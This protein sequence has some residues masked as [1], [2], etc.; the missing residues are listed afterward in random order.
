MTKL[1]QKL[2]APNVKRGDKSF[3]PVL[4]H[5]QRLGFKSRISTLPYE[6]D[7]L[8]PKLRDMSLNQSLASLAFGQ[9]I[10]VT[11]LQMAMAAAAVA[12]GGT[13]RPPRLVSAIEDDDGELA[14]VPAD[15]A[16]VHPVFTPATGA[17]VKQML[18]R[19]VEEGGTAK[20]RPRGWSMGGKTGTAQDEKHHE[21]SIASY[22]CF[23]PVADPR[24]LV[25]VVLYNPKHGRFAADNAAKIAGGVM[26]ELLNSFEVPSDRP[27]ELL[28]EAARAAKARAQA[29][30][31]LPPRLS[32]M[33]SPAVGEGR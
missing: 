22:W 26:G 20:W 1:V 9:E 23:A 3:Q 17:T 27:E 28:A 14:P 21:R 31:R 19:V 25:L 4:D 18:V 16:H 15:L 8:L 33:S 2:V 13:W 5:I 30:P 24:F 29:S 12:N 7:G 6:E 32:L 11:T 10:G